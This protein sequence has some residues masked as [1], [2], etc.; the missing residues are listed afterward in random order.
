M[1]IFK[2]TEKIF[3]TNSIDPVAFDLEQLKCTEVINYSPC[4]C[5]FVLIN[6]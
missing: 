1:F 3:T 6:I 4:V 5:I 2:K